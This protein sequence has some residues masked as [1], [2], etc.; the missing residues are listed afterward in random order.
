MEIC[1]E[2]LDDDWGFEFVND[3]GLIKWNGRDVSVI[4][5]SES[6]HH[7]VKPF[8][9]RPPSKVEGSIAGGYDEEGGGYVEGK[10][11]FKWESEEKDDFATAPQEADNDHVAEVVSSEK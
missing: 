1:N 2:S 10:I 7:I 9:S 11:T 6:I 8:M 3:F 4:E 5:E